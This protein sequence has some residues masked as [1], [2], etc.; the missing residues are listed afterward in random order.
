MK[1]STVIITRNEEDT[2]ARAIRSVSFSSE[3][4]VVDSYSTDRTCDIA[5][6]LGAIVHQNP[7]RNH[8]Q[9]KNFAASLACGEWILSIDADEEVSEQLKG[10]LLEAI[11]LEGPSV[12]RLLRRTQYCGR[13]IYHGGWYPDYILRLY[14][15]GEARWTEP[16]V[17]EKLLP[18]RPQ[19]K[20]KTLSGHLNHY[21]FPTA[22]SQVKANVY[23]A[24]LGAKELL[25]K[26]RRKKTRP[27]SLLLPMLFKP[28]G[29][30]LECYLFKR[31][32]LDGW[33][34]FIIAVNAAHSTFM[35]YSF[36]AMETMGI[37]MGMGTG[38]RRD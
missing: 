36:A 11:S 2:I 28:W 3:V 31:G 22:S 7:F 24:S 30:F 20:T 34:G 5:R 1:I 25:A 18:T 37:G 6:D 38:Q 9:Q 32:L 33:P 8:G 14:R 13:W 17:H 23:Y 21:S 4:I 29:K 12:Y 26:S 10:P 27:L 35:K 16:F 15:K 19:G